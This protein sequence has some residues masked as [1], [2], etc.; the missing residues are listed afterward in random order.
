MRQLNCPI[1]FNNIHPDRVVGQNAYCTCGHVLRVSNSSSDRETSGASLS[2][3]IFTLILIGA[4]IHA[5]NWDT[6]F[7]S[8]I[9]LKIK[10]MSGI[11]KPHEL[12]DLAKICNIRK[13]NNCE[14]QALEKAYELDKAD[15]NSLLR[16][17]EIYTDSKNFYPAAKAYSLYFQNGGSTES[18]RYQYARALGEIGQFDQAKKQFHYIL[19]RDK[20]NPQFQ[21]A[22]SY[23]ELLIRN[24]DYSTAKGIIEEYR[25][26]GPNSA[27][28]LEKEWKAINDKLGRSNDKR[29]TR[30][31]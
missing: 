3:I 19:R 26:A 21:V 8:I 10:Q 15:I 16:I 22:R 12:K 9:P 24:R 13:K 7:F 30:G 2:L 23:V 14:V 25:R 29:K 17:G 31:A 27:L 28:F 11:A 6:Y 18:A 1:C 4:I 20:K 5:I